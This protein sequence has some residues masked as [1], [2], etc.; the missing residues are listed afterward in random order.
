MSAAPWIQGVRNLLCIVAASLIVVGLHAVAFADEVGTAAQVR[1]ASASFTRR[2]YISVGAGISILK[3]DDECPCLVV[4]DDQDT[5]VHVAIGYDFTRWI[6][7]EV[8]FTD[9]GQAE[10]EFLGDAVG[11]IE[12]QVSG[13]SAIAYL[14][15][16]QSGFGFTDSANGV[17]RR[18]GLSLY[19]RVGLGGVNTNSDLDMK[20][21]HSSHVAFGVGVEYGF[22]NGFALRGEITS[23]DTD[24]QYVSASI[25][26][27]FGKV[28]V[29]VPVAVA[30]PI[31]PA[32]VTPATPAPAAIGSPAIL[33]PVEMPEINFAFDRH[34]LSPADKLELD[35]L[36]E[37]IRDFDV[38]LQL[39]GHT[40]WVASERYNY[41][42]SLRRANSVR[43]Y[44][45]S[46]GISGG[47]MSVAG[48]GETRPLG[49]NTTRQGRALNRRTDI[50]LLGQ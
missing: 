8:Y 41:N 13:A 28:P 19:G 20:R 50:I 33:G 12:Y 7:A 22:T 10:I 38:R 45:M 31:I 4:S 9:L 24:A 27:R 35:K 39:D 29:A 2:P 40:D 16:N 47:R 3:P 15:N 21:D 49:E 36:A 17:F 37:I 44:L 14:Y 23:Y 46:L 5:G 48:Y 25:L 34:D 11:P 32:L 43:Q 26:K 1:A 42:L 30:A 6:S 18:E